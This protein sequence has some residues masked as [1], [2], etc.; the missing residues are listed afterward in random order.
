M[1]HDAMKRYIIKFENGNVIPGSHTNGMRGRDITNEY[2]IE[3]RIN[4]LSFVLTIFIEKNL[5]DIAKLEIKY[6]AHK[7]LH[8]KKFMM[9]ILWANTN[10]TTPF[11]CY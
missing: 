4:R 5:N 2:T 1:M 7:T 9:C 6:E 11:E 10:I 8:T 3:I